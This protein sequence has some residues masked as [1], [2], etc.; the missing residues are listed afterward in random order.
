MNSS[1]NSDSKDEQL[2][3]SDYLK[4]GRQ[5]FGVLLLI[6]EWG[7]TWPFYIPPNV[8]AEIPFSNE[9]GMVVRVRLIFPL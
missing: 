9:M 5:K 1:Q 8:I 7:T 2:A 3:W 4:E 6:F